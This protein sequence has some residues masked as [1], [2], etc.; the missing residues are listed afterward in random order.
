MPL[1]S[2]KVTVGRTYT[3]IDDRTD[4]EYF[5]ELEVQSL[6]LDLEVEKQGSVDMICDNMAYR[7]RKGEEK[8]DDE[9]DEKE[10]EEEEED[11]GEEADSNVKSEVEGETTQRINEIKKVKEMM[12]ETQNLN[13]ADKCID[14]NTKIYKT[15]TIE[16][17]EGDVKES[18]K[19][20]MCT[21]MA[22]HVY[23]SV[24]AVHHEL[25]A[26][27]NNC[28]QTREFINQLIHGQINE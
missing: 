24:S 14:Y 28:A 21:K 26:Y 5:K 9:E 1:R 3:D 4:I 17:V 11:K 10:E 15:D 22:Y 12:R 2:I 27:Q 13:I 18:A 19:A 25:S 8:D 20:L 6:L 7:E 23:D 16:S